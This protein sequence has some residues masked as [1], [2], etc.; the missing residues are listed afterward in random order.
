MKATHRHTQRTRPVNAPE[1][2]NP[3]IEKNKLRRLS[4]V[5]ALGLT[6][7]GLLELL[8]RM[9][10]QLLYAPYGIT[11]FMTLWAILCWGGVSL[12]VVHQLR[13][14]RWVTRTVGLGAFFLAFSQ[15]ISLSAHFGVPFTQYLVDNH[16][17]LHPLLE[18]G[19]FVL[20]LLFLIAGFYMS[21]FEARKSNIRMQEEQQALSKEVGPRK[22]VQL[23]LM[24]S[25]EALRNANEALEERV[26]ERTAELTE[27]N[28]LLN[29]EIVKRR[30]TEA[31]LRESELKYRMIVDNSVDRIWQTDLNLTFTYINPTSTPDIS[32]TP[33]QIIGRSL[34]AFIG[35]EEFRR[36]KSLL[37]QALAAGSLDERMT[38]ETQTLT[39]TGAIE[40]IEVHV[41][42]LLDTEGR[43]IGIQ[44][45]TRDINERKR[46]EAE[47]ER[48]QEQLL[49]AQKMESVGR[50]AG[51]V[52]HDFNNMLGLIIGHTELLMNKLE[53][54]SPLRTRLEGILSAAERSADLTRQ[55][56]AFARKQTV[57]P[58]ALDLNETVSGMLDMLRRT[59]GEHIDVRWRPG[60]ALWLINMDI[61]QIDQILMNLCLNAR[62]AISDTGKI[63]VE[64]ANITLDE[65]H[66][67]RHAD[68]VPGAYVMIAVSDDGAGM[69]REVLR[70]IF[71]PFYT[72]KG[73]H[74]GTGL[75]LATVYGIVKQNNGFIN[76]YSEP[77]SG[78][79]FKVYLPRHIG[80]P[81][82]PAKDVVCSTV[83]GNETVLL[84][85]DKVDFLEM[86]Q[87]M[88]EQQGYRILTASTPAKALELARTYKDGIHLLM[89][90]VI[91]PEMNGRELADR[92]R[93]LHPN[94]KCLFMSGYTANVIAHHGVLEEGVHFLQ[95]PF[96]INELSAKI[97]EALAGA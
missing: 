57:T 67:A 47:R 3:T 35:P 28:R 46:A 36:F 96:S 72:T 5:I 84:V 71:E 89:T 54:D 34:E 80:A 78:T 73:M 69:D 25:E 44:G 13:S 6:T 74:Q 50:L 21:L 93:A 55:L 59:I 1:T 88:L 38:V 23:A 20:G 22:Q 62:D 77:D 18:E 26:R 61:G 94:I 11:G 4:W 19:A 76:V 37:E 24:R 81:A 33:D 7:A 17:P 56:L 2:D 79:C 97:R 51:G 92:L 64:T 29:D 52:A 12:Y 27:I 49:Q 60:A 43:P 85:E 15:G 32:Y 45:L 9:L 41:R 82:P 70:H 53:P 66:C 75:G 95:K 14:A 86:A 48:L 39:K 65:S 68:C 90:D 83:T 87:V 30:E 8:G 16:F 10:C 58:K 42:L 40:T 63:T 91:M 31:A